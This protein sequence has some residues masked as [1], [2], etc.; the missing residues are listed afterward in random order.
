MKT[1]NP[2][3]LGIES[4]L[5]ARFLRKGST[6]YREFE[7]TVLVIELQ[8]SNYGD[9]YYV[10]L[11]VFVKSLTPTPVKLPPREYKCH[12]RC[13]AESLIS[14]LEEYFRDVVLNIDAES[15]EPS[16]R[17]QRVHDLIADVAV[18]F[19]LGCSTLAGIRE[20]YQQGR[21]DSALIHWGV[22]ESVL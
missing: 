17:Q 9:E 7:E 16:E 13:R 20:A 10:N 22:R 3:K 8:K 11:G 19:L 12:I 2:I 6:W 18:P 14:E 4:A 15:L 5:K 21:L 1:S